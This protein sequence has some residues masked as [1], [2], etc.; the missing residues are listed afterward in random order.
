MDAQRG[1]VFGQVFEREDGQARPVTDAIAAL[2]AAVLQHH[3]EW[4]RGSV[5]E[6]DGAIRYA[7]DIRD[8]LGDQARVAAAVPH[9]AHAIARIAASAPDRA[10][11]PHAV[12]PIY[13]R[14]PDAEI[15]RDRRAGA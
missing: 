12:V 5:F 4:V 14:K 2:P 8:G 9:L 3:R 15:A 6:G 11:L 10:V 1:E 13:V 7:A